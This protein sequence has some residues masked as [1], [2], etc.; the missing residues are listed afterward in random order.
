MLPWWLP[1]LIFV[2][3]F[4]VLISLAFS[5]NLLVIAAIF[6][7]RKLR[8]QPEN[9]FLVSLAL[10]DLFVAGMVFKKIF[11]KISKFFLKVMVLAAANDLIGFWPFGAAFCQFWIC[12][13][14]AC[15]T[16][17]ILNLVGY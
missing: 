2:P 4:S 15:S 12:L 3:L 11:E 7:D 17:S 6:Y 10:S 9:L 8:R 5:G 13:D 14:I 16:A 1:L